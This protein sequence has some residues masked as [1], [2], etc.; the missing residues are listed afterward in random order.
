MAAYRGGQGYRLEKPTPA[1]YSTCYG[2]RFI[3]SK[4]VRGDV[5]CPM[6][7]G[8]SILQEIVSGI[9]FVMPTL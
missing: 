4:Y 6:S 8:M 5:Y 3:P 7:S 2:S 1:V 9:N